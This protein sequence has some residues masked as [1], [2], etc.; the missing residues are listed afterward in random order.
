MY[1][2]PTCQKTDRPHPC[3]PWTKNSPKLVS[4]LTKDTEKQPYQFERWTAQ[5]RCRV[6]AGASRAKIETSRSLRLKGVKRLYEMT[7]T[8]ETIWTNI[9]ISSLPVSSQFGGVAR[10]HTRVSR[11]KR[12]DCRSLTLS[13]AA[14]FASHNCG[15]LACRLMDAAKLYSPL[16]NLPLPVVLPW[17]MQFPKKHLALGWHSLACLHFCTGAVSRQMILRVIDVWLFCTELK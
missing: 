8:V 17:Q 7:V 5:P 2:A 14:S 4:N 6:A 9:R 1:I 12:S 3:Q 10:G 15:E 11:E 13:F 16:Q